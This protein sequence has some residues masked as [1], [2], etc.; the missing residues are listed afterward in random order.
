MGFMVRAFVERYADDG[1]HEE[2]GLR[3]ALEMDFVDVLRK[4]RSLMNRG[5]PNDVSTGVEE[6]LSELGEEFG[7][8]SWATLE[9]L[10]RL[11]LEGV[12]EERRLLGPHLWRQYREKGTA[13]GSEVNEKP[14]PSWSASARVSCRTRR[15]TPTCRA[16]RVKP[17]R[18][19]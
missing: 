11:P 15:W 2:R 10:L 18:A 1:W 3:A 16:P 7:S 14:L 12:V 17:K 19:E 9:E 6:G 4:K 8:E 13:N 5:I